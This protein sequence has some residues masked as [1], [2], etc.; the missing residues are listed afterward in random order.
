MTSVS[1]VSYVDVDL[2]RLK[3][4]YMLRIRY[5]DR[6]GRES[7]DEYLVYPIKVWEKVEHV[8]GPLLEGRAP[9]N[10]GVI[11]IGPPGTGKSS[12]IRVVPD[13]LG[14]SVVEVGAERVLSK[15]VGESEKFMAAIFSEA[16]RLQPSAVLVDEGDWILSPSR[17]TAGLSEVSSNV[18]GI[19]KRYLA[20]FYREGARSLVMF[21]AN[22]AESAIDSTLKREG[23]CG[24]PVVIP[25][26][27]F[28]AVYS[29]LTVAGGL[30]PKTAE[31]MALDFVNAGL[32]MADVVSKL[33][34]YLEV[35]RYSVEP[36]RYRG[37]RRLVS[38]ASLLEDPDV[39]TLLDRLDA[40][41]WLCRVAEY[42][43]ARVWISDLPAVVS[44]PIASAVFGLKC[45]KPV[46]LVDHSK[47]IDEAVD[48]V[49]LL[50]AVAVVAHKS[51]HPEVLRV[52][53]STADFPIVFVGRE[54]PL[55]YAEV[56][57][58]K[59]GDVVAHHR[60]G[61]AKL[62]ADTYG[63]QLE[64]E[65]WSR[66]KTASTQELLDMLYSLALAGR[67]VKAFKGVS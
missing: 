30:D 37:Y 61:A 43:R 36:M 66:L 2:E 38:P 28:E 25:L 59:V 42:R 62:V 63:V 46:V 20:D 50:G 10:P 21:A 18:L 35:G 52:L 12:L 51:L 58:L 13:Y 67:L 60:T 23:R 48:M 11:F 16:L 45:R 22:L 65:D 4:N 14:L 7:R 55:E 9:R 29:Y 15:W 26:P 19:V 17:E 56:H 6:F 47:Y 5:Y 24:K 41:F 40:A 3:H 34:S 27:D 32:S 54:S 64:Q 53:W 1:V 57:Q 49:N 33:L 39:N 31:R 44:L 8:I